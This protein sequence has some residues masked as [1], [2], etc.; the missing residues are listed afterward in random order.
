MRMPEGRVTVG[1]CACQRSA[2]RVGSKQDGREQKQK[3]KRK[4]TTTTRCIGQERSHG[5]KCIATILIQ[6]SAT[7]INDVGQADPEAP[8]GFKGKPCL[9]QVTAAT[10]QISASSACNQSVK[11]ALLPQDTVQGV[12]PVWSQSRRVR[13]R[14]TTL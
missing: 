10:P 14:I 6:C 2:T 1:E 7:R 13:G 12:K 9:V 4:N 3:N 5:G 8:V 11:S